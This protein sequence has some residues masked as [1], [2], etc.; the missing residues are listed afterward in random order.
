ML[1]NYYNK[2]YYYNNFY[3]SRIHIYLARVNAWKSIYHGR[4]KKRI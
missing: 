3:Y 4:T 1:S 2:N